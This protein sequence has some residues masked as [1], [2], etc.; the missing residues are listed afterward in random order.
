VR[1]D[2]HDFVPV[3]EEALRA[4]HPIASRTSSTPGRW[5]RPYRRTA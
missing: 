1:F 2:P 5:T 3:Q 4:W